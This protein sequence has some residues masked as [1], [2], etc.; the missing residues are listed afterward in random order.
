[1]SVFL[2]GRIFHCE[3]MWQGRPV[4]KTTGQTTI[5]K[6]RT[7]ETNE[8]IRLQKMSAVT[9]MA[10]G[11]APLL[12]E[13]AAEFLAEM[14]AS[15]EA[16]TLDADTERYYRCG[17]KWLEAHDI[18]DMRVNQITTGMAAGLKFPGGPSTARAA[19]Q[20]LGRLLRW[21]AKERGYMQA[22]PSIKRTRYKGRSTRIPEAQQDKLLAHMD[23]DCADIFRLEMDMFMRPAEIMA[24][25]WEDVH[26]EDREPWYYV[27]RGKSETSRRKLRM[28][29]LAIEIL[30]A[31]KRRGEWVFPARCK[32]HGHRK[33]IW[34]Q[35]AAA[36]KAAGVKGVWLYDGKRE[37]ASSFMECGGDLMT[38]QAALGHADI[39]TTSKYLH[40]QSEAA[41]DV[42]NKRNNRRGLR[43]VKE[44]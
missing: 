39:S 16:G 13:V 8:R 21:A 18:W 11:K 37:C 20:T 25:R 30:T 6:A 12:H 29:A 14:K 33:T 40:G 7:F 4:R 35:F 32:K 5:G 26:L 9:R 41:A 17:C 10:G 42:I 15:A 2:R 44:A 23:R 38:L 27:P 36:R 31:R 3:F 24:M 19:Q 1:M 28:S 34:K 22:A 43:P